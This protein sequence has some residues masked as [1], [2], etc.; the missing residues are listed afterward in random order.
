VTNREMGANFPWTLVI[1]PLEREALDWIR[2]STP[3]NA[4]VQIEPYI[5]GSKHWSY[6]TGFAERR[7]IAG[8][9]IAMTP[10]RPYREA[11][12]YVYFGVFRAR[13]ADEAHNMARFL[14]IN[15]LA[16]GIPERRAYAAG[17]ANMAS[18]P[19]LFAPVFRNN[20]MTIFRVE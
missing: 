19:D 4:V 11:A 6:I 20:E 15:F 16:A 18:R 14:G 1:T 8:F 13:S 9:P 2:V 12:D 7:S 3:P 10:M 5:R 17:I